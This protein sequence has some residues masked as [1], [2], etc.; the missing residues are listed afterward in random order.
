MT[1]EKVASDITD[2][3]SRPIAS[4]KPVVTEILRKDGDIILKTDELSETGAQAYSR[5]SL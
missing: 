5:L 2:S 3:F 1:L 4:P